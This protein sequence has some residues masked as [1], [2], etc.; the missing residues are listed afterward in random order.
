MRLFNF[1]R[2]KTPMELSFEG[3]YKKWLES[4]REEEEQ[5][6]NTNNLLT[7]IASQLH[8]LIEV[9]KDQRGAIVEFNHLNSNMVRH[10]A[11]FFSLKVD[12]ERNV[13]E[14]VIPVP[15]PADLE[16]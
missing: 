11:K 5:R 14:R 10:M 15:T 7:E 2:K 4:E 3:F 12:Q 13:E 6:E 8:E 16:F 9:S 1:K